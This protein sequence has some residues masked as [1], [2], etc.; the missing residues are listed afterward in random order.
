[1]DARNELSVSYIHPLYHS[2]P[3]RLVS[4]AIKGGAM[5]YLLLQNTHLCI[6]IPTFV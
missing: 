1:M 3:S 2:I 4:V 6:V 5:V